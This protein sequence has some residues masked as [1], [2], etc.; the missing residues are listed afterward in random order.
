MGSARSLTKNTK[1]INIFRSDLR[2]GIALYSLAMLIFVV[3]DSFAKGLVGTQHIVQVVWLRFAFHFVTLC[4]LVPQKRTIAMRF[5]TRSFKWHAARG[6]CLT[7]MTFLF[8]T[9]LRYV[10]LAEANILASTAPFVVAILAVALL[11]E[12]IGAFRW[13]M[14]CAGFV[15]ALIVIRPG[16]GFLH[17]G[18]VFPLLT[19]VCFAIVQLVSRRLARDENA[20][21]TLLYSA[22]L[23]T[24]VVTPLGLAFWESPG[25]GTLTLMAS[26][27]VAAAAGDTMLLRSIKL[28]PASTVAPFQY[29]QIVWAIL[30]GYI[31]F[32]EL[33]DFVGIIG[34]SIIVA[35]G[36]A[37]MRHT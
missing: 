1:G 17:W 27:G 18:A 33:T 4:V 22:G 7:L 16:L 13:A 29:T 20:W 31:W 11:G 34:A 14:I 15:G 23:G 35:S 30:I 10:P 32:G 21:T 37:L 12:H 26:V 9:G 19:A 36:L 28:A 2:A 8:Y 25:V 5:R 3:M 6:L 24:V